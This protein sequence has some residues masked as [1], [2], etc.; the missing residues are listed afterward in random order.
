M[1]QEYESEGTTPASTTLPAG[2]SIRF[3][4]ETVGTAPVMVMLAA[5][6]AGSVYV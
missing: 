4:S 5:A 2:T 3:E 6:G 1:N